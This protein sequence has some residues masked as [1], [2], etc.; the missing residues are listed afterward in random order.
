MTDELLQA[1]TGRPE[2][3]EAAVLT[4]TARD[5]RRWRVAYVVPAEGT[6]V[7]RVRRT[8]EA[9]ALTLPRPAGPPLAVAVVSGIPRT[10]EGVPDESALAVLPVADT[11]GVPVLAAPAPQVGR[12]HLGEL[13]ALPPRWATERRVTPDT[14]VGPAGPAPVDRDA[15]PAVA[16]GAPVVAEPGDPATLPEALLRAAERWP[17]RGVRVV[18]ADGTR[19]LSYPELLA[20]ARRTLGGLRAA[21]LS[22]GDPV[23]LHVPSLADHFVALWACLLGGLRAVAVA[24]APGYGARN[25]TLD[26]LEHAWRGLGHPVVLSGGPTVGHLVGYAERE[27]IVGLR[28]LDVA[29]CADHPP[30][31]ELPPPAPDD[32]AMLQLSS[33]STSRSKVIPLTHRGIVGYARGARQVGRMRTGDEVLNWLPLDHVG[34]IVMM[35]LG[36]VVLGCGTTHVATGLVLADP[37]LWLDLLQRHEVRHSWSPNFGY[38]LVSEALRG[39]PDRDW[40]L[41]GVRSLINAGEQCTAPVTRRF[42]ADVRRFGVRP[43]VL[44][45]AWGMAETCTAISYQPFDDSSVQHVELH[46]DGTRVRLRDSPGPGATS[47]LT[48]GVPA[49]GAR[50]RIAAPDGRTARPERHIGRLQVTSDRVTPGYLGNDEAN[51]AAFPDGAWFDTGDLAFLAGGRLTVTGREKEVIIVNGVHH[52]CHEIEDAVGGVDGVAA[53]FVAA[54]GAPGADGTEQVVV[55]FVDERGLDANL[56]ARIRGRLAERLQLSAVRLVPIGRDAFG[57]TTSGKIQRSGMR[58]RLLSGGY[59]AAQRRVEVL[60][61]GPDTVPDCVHRLAWA[62]RSLPAGPVPGPVLVIGDRLG[63]ATA[64]RDALPDVL[65]VDGAGRPGP[66]APALEAGTDGVERGR[67]FGGRQ[68]LPGQVVFAASYLPTPAPDDASAVDAAVE[69]CGNGALDLLRTLADAGWTGTLL[70]LSR[71]LYRIRGDEPGCYPAALTAG[72]AETFAVEHPGVTA[73]HLDLPG[74]DVAE[75]AAAVAMALGWTHREPVVAWRDGPLVRTLHRD[76]PAVGVASAGTG[77]A[78]GGVRGMGDTA[79][80]GVGGG[81]DGGGGGG[82]AGPAVPPGTR[83]LVTGGLGGVARTVLGRLATDLDLH[84]LVVGRTPA[85]QAVERLAELAD[86]GARVHYSAVDVTDGDALEAAVAAAE[87]RWQAPLDGVLHLAGDYRHAPL[88][89]AATRWRADAAA[90]VDGSLSVVRLLRRRPGSRL[91]AF[92]SLLTLTPVVGAGSYVAGN[93]FVEALCEHLRPELPAHCVSWGLWR[94]VGLAAAQDGV[95]QATRRHLLAFSPTE[96]RA[97][98]R[99]A[100]H[101]P[102]GHLLVGVNPDAGRVRHLLRPVRPLEG[103]AAGTPDPVDAFGTPA[104]VVPCPAAPS[105]AA[106]PSGGTG[107]PAAGPGRQPTPAPGAPPPPTPGP[108][109]AVAGTPPPAVNGT[110]PLAGAGTP[111]PAANGTPPLAGARPAEVGAPA[112]DPLVVARLVREVLRE[113]V[114]GTADDRTAFHDAGLDSVRLV[115]LHIRL[116]QALG[117]QFPLVTL[118]THGTPAAL[119]AHLVELLCGA[120]PRRDGPADAGATDDRRIAIV[121]MALRFPGA[122]TAGRYWR[123][124]LA[125]QVDVR[126][127]G[128]DELLAAG[129]PAAV[130]DD[131]AFVPVSGALDDIEGFDAE[132]FGITPRE[133]ALTDPQ[134]RLFLQ[135]CH[136]ALEDGGYAGTDRRVGVYAGSGMHLYSLRSYLLDR[137]AGTD[138]TDQLAAL[139]VTIGN[140]PDFLATR[141]AYRLGLTGPAL[142]VQTACSTSLVAVHLAVRSLL[143]GETDLALAGAAALHVPRVAGYRHAAGSILSRAGVCRAFDAEADGTVGGNGVAAVLLKRLGDALADG[144]TVHA[145]ILGTAVNNDGADKSGYTAPTVGGHAAVIREALSVAGVDPASVG[146]LET[147]GT[148]TPVGD[149]IEV[150]A[151]HAVFGQRHAP[152]P[153]GAVKANIGHLDTCA[154]MAG[155]IKAALAVRHGQ[156]PPLANLRRPNP[157]LRLAEGP[158]R[159]PTSAQPWPVPGPRRAGVSSL[160]VGGTNAHVVV[161]EPPVTAPADP[162]TGPVVVPLSAHT[163]EA[164]GLLADRVADRLAAADPPRAQD[165]LVTLSTGRR[166]RR[167]RRVA[168]AA[169]PGAAAAL[170]RP[171]AR[172]APSPVGPDGDVLPGTVTGTVPD[173]GPGPVVFALTGQ[174]VDCRAAAVGLSAHEPAREVLERCAAQYRQA[175]GVDLLAAMRG[176]PHQWTTATV[177][178]ALFA[179][180]VA[181]ARL[182]ESVGVRPDVLIGHSAGE[183]AALCL[184]G[185]LSVEDGL[186]LAA[187]RGQLM[188]GGTPPGAALAVLADESVLDRLL[189]QVDGVERTVRNGPRRHV[190]A[191][192]P[193]AVRRLGSLLDDAKVPH[194]P[195]PVD[196]AFHSALLEP[197]LDDLAARAATLT[198]RPLHTSFVTGLG[199]ARRT[200]GTLLGSEHVRRQTRERA[201]YAA[202]VD[203]LVADGCT[204]FVELGPGAVLTGLGRQWPDTTWIPVRGRRGDSQDHHQREPAEPVVA[205]LASLFCR[206]VEVDWAALAPGGRRVPLPTHPFRP[207]RHWVETRPATPAVPSVEPGAGGSPVMSTANPANPIDDLVLRQV[208][209]LTAGQLGMEPDRVPADTPFF[210]LGAD[211]LLM[212]NL[213]RELETAFGIRI[214]MRELFEDLDSPHRLTA[215]IVERMPPQRRATL[216]GAAAPV[217]GTPP[218]PAATS[219][220]PPAIGVGPSGPGGTG[221]TGGTG[222]AGGTGGPRDPGGTGGWPGLAVTAAGSGADPLDGE[223]AAVPASTSAAT[224]PAPTAPATLPTPAVPA[225]TMPAAHAYGAGVVGAAPAHDPGALSVVHSQLALMGQFTD[226]MARQ[227]SALGGVPSPAG[228]PDSLPHQPAP[229]APA[230]M[231]APPGPVAPGPGIALPAAPPAA[232]RKT[233]APSTDPPAAAVPSAEEPAAQVGPRPVA[234]GAGMGGNRLDAR[235]QAHLADLVRRYVAKTPTS[236]ELTQRHRARL[237]D[238]RAVVGFRRTTKEMLYPLAARRARG[239]RLE[240]VD[241]NSYLDITMGFGA[242]LFGH[243]P[244]FLTRAVAAHLDDGLRLGPRGAEAGEAAELL[245]ELTGMDRAAFATTGTEANSAAFRLARAYTGR[246]LV[247]TFTGSYHGH[248][249]P[250]LGSGVRSGDGWRTVPVS[251]GIPD[252]AVAD[253]LVLPYDDAQSLDVIARAADRIAAVVVEPVRSR[254]PDRQPAEFLRALRESCDRHGMVLLFDEMLTGFRPHVRGAQ[255]VFG[256]QADLATYGKVIGGGFPVG[257]VAGRADIMDWVDGGFWRYGDDSAP[258]QD[259]TFFGGTYIQH[260]VSMVAVR[261]VLSELRRRGPALQQGLNRRTERLA[262]TINDFCAAEDFPL[263]VRHFGSLFRFASTADLDLLFHHLLLAGVYVWEW[264]NFFLSD[265][266]TDADVDVVADAVRQSLS[267]LRAGGFLPGGLGT[268]ATRAAPAP[269]PAPTPAPAAMPTAPTAPTAGNRSASAPVTV[270]RLPAGGDTEFGAA[271]GGSRSG[272]GHPPDL[273]LYFFGD[274]P[275]ESVQDRYAAVLDA[276]EFADTHGLYAVWLPE[277]HFDSFGGIFPNPSVL[278][279][280]VAARTRR[281][282]VHAGC[283]VLPLHDPIRVAEEWSVVDNL[284]GGR[285]GIGCASGW[286]ARDFVLAPQAY[287]RHREVMYES[288][289]QIRDL[290]RGLPV[291]RTAGNGEPVQVRLFPRPVQDLPPLFTAVV[292]NPDSY[293][294]AAAA[295]L[296]IITNLMAQGV[297]ELA[298]NIALYRR[299]RVEHGLAPNG[300]VVLL[301][302]TYLGPDGDRART[303]AFG[304]FCAYLRSSLAL[305]GQVTNSLGVTIDLE[306]TAPEDVDFLLER[307]YQRYTT[308]RALIGSPQEARAVVERLAAL[309]VD[310]IGCFVD[311]G[312]PPDRMLAGLTGIDQLGALLRRPDPG[313]PPA[314]DPTAPTDDPA[315]TADGPTAGSV[316]ADDPTGTGVPATEAQREIWF[317]ER[318]LPRRPTYT[319]SQVVRLD[320]P[321]DVAA[322]RTAVALVVRRHPAL[323]STFREVDGEPR[324]LA[325]PPGP[326]ELPVRDAAGEDVA[327]AAAR[328]AREETA[329]RFDLSAGPLF[330]P[331]LVRIDDR[332]HLLVLRMH[333]LVIDTLSA[334]V[335]AREIAAGY[336]AAIAGR[337][338]ELP[339]PPPW[340]V[341]VDD[342]PAETADEQLAYWTRRLAGPLPRLDLP[343]DRPRPATPSGVGAVAGG[344]LDAELTRA[345]R[346]FGRRCRATPFMVLLAGFAAVLGDQGR[347]PDLVIGAPVAHRPRD[348]R[349]AVGLFVTMLPLRLAVAGGAGLADLVRCART[350]LLDA[351]EHRDVPLHRVV[352]ALGIEPEA[353]RH[354]LFDVVVEYDNEAVFELDLPGVRATL[355]DAAVERAPF[356]LTLFLTDLGDTVRCQLHY[357]TDLF[358]AATARRVLDRLAE[359]LRAGIRRPDE[360]LRAL[361]GPIATGS[362]PIARWQ[363]GGPPAE[364]ADAELPGLL[365]VRRAVVVDPDGEQLPGPELDR[366]ADAVAAALAAAGVGRGDLVGVQLPRSADAVAAM[367]GVLWAGAAYVPLAPEQ[368]AARLAGIVAR[369]GIRV[370]VSR[371][372]TP[373]LTDTVTSLHMDRLAPGAP[374]AVAGSDPTGAAAAAAPDGVA[375]RVQRAGGSPEDLAYVIFTS[376]STGRPKGCVIGHGAIANTVAWY[377]RDLGITARDRLSWFCSPGFDASGIEVWP[378]LRAGATLHV[379]PDDVR[380]DA[381]RLRDWLVD[382]GVTVSMVPTPVGELLL[383]Q[384]WSAGPRP[385]LRHLVVGGDRL[386]RGVP[387]DLPFTVTNVYGPTEATVV[388]TWAHLDAADGDVPPI[389]R[390]VPGTWVRVLDDDGRPVPVGVP[391]E[392][393]LGGV[394]LGRG[395]L[396]A[397]EETAARFLRHPGLG[398]VFR[399]GDVVRWRADGQLEFLHRTDAQ[400]QIRGFRVEP[401]EAEHHLRGLDGVHDAAVRAWP[402]ADGRAYLAGYVVPARDGVDPSE[403]ARR[404]AGRLPEYLVPTAWT[405]LPALPTTDSG[406][407]DRAALPEPDL[408][409]PRRAGAGTAPATALERRLHDAWCTELGA[410]AIGVETSFFELGGTS[411]TALRLLNRVAVETGGTDEVLDFLRRPTIRA[412]AHRLTL[413]VPAAGRADPDQ[414]DTDQAGDGDPT[415]TGTDRPERVRGW[416]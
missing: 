342:V 340:P 208:R 296:G 78:G 320:G 126:R 303:E 180:Q 187:V 300:R 9:A 123:N 315:P 203:A 355:L 407:I 69:V 290:W 395:Y 35:H 314:D 233:L 158:F 349:D 193:G 362:D 124:L 156:V 369:A 376:G 185:A 4:R 288:V 240:D 101:R 178:P 6:P 234:V 209:E 325:G 415:E 197:V 406:K 363:D 284:S 58:A 52:F 129:W 247:V 373:P 388:S 128:R 368:P 163:P 21:G 96:G 304:P 109:P 92:S 319:E 53:S 332:Q 188:Q 372:S 186:H 271:A 192:P 324:Q 356:D 41:R 93:R 177:Q 251:A 266:H 10:A 404:L 59:E 398:P 150:A 184:A 189:E 282:R 411:L 394:Q 384:D 40:D 68:S 8:A 278:A 190:V 237:A 75:D 153:L 399:T 326:V 218:G 403:L 30:A 235:Q 125:G 136:E 380:L 375:A 120:G 157:Q 134:Q 159:L 82:P 413:S 410:E 351:H 246:P 302:H 191:G 83:W 144:D 383:D 62:P 339:Q 130:V 104:P 63:L 127:F 138:P 73:R 66:V 318:M 170:L 32:V 357:A 47:F 378:A 166:R 262:A 119:V 161:E 230:G 54:V 370:V 57:K 19:L 265:A 219:A 149:P 167:H 143:A 139:Q 238:S 414:A 110:P 405:V 88:A 389:G 354:P 171:T 12:R 65:V 85:P 112:R 118:F 268:P 37:L 226:L 416:L 142:S 258:P 212:I 267:D 168:W 361:L 401:G 221:G 99:L 46:A 316:A 216:A 346:D 253:V 252:S 308:D 28:V 107:A 74:R 331:R 336:R 77:D 210:D 306:R 328:A 24:Q 396:D 89:G 195:L 200:P 174:G 194:R 165:V 382:T 295:D 329:H 18:E 379:V 213:L 236:R 132:M 43:D 16:Q 133:A 2:I 390:P 94:G 367:L 49:P 330:A 301:L 307:A 141:V 257:A 122:D 204:T 113:T 172:D 117:A 270:P 305:F 335:L 67:A 106:A 140:Q 148:G 182:L 1:L 215:A 33:G 155:L 97:L 347:Q 313:P 323:R 327:S 259:T 377:T 337:P 76:V 179:V 70:T 22:P 48:M 299:T 248:F 50:F 333:H 291:T 39:H 105:P 397:P 231:V 289:A 241:G 13:V 169:T 348:A 245:C 154:G 274:Y 72:L 17:Q 146:Y 86:S 114:P 183:Y 137:L 214:A 202:G 115:R 36:P 152:L 263:R 217:P 279:A 392:L 20:A 60:E 298:D 102:P 364:G 277:R 412:M 287:G 242:L 80:L 385:A 309:G 273:S 321:L 116:Q 293:R 160:G 334:G 51:R 84:L 225:A 61:A 264:R 243:E 205:A 374:G 281:V 108:P 280:A 27:G 196:R 34:G 261:A 38:K 162:D 164:L 311:F 366:R 121:G 386:R 292:G 100:L 79:D 255:G 11:V 87:R 285:V 71:G 249:D 365:D 173:G 387:A 229:A 409:A 400:V 360:P 44:L 294:R 244:E 224:L 250:V 223:T 260:P 341:P 31:E 353:G 55:L 310:E 90:K 151:L 201:D 391:G 56:L 256:V 103:V 227:L 297:A 272:P 198:W 175:W 145:V 29:R 26:K 7:D 275:Q 91:V 220:A 228:G 111:P 402:D 344:V 14:V 322:L 283:A 131:D 199:G 98:T 381:G 135:V 25:A 181:Q 358:D 338:V 42:L 345:V 371:S 350:A 207:T 81:V 206:G 15:P 352:R 269:A 359:V 254:Y 64:L 23:V 239:A 232:S 408:D 317:A 45:L 343:T 95:E 211:S 5:G 286:H 3:A 222:G 147:H 312:L 393:Y 176:G 276:A